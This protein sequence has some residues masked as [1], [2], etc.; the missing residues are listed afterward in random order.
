[1]FHSF[2]IS[3]LS[4]RE[5]C[6]DDEMHAFFDLSAMNHVIAARLIIDYDFS[7]RLS[8]S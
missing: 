7:K 2:I 5:A 8:Q 4:I 6:A 1:M 3:C